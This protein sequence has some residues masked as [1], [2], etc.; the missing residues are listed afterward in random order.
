MAW[1]GCRKNGDPHKTDSSGQRGNV[2]GGGRWT[3]P[4]AALGTPGRDSRAALPPNLGKKSRD[5]SHHREGKEKSPSQ[6][7]ERLPKPSPR[8]GGRQ[9]PSLTLAHL[10]GSF[11]LQLIFALLSP[12]ADSPGEDIQNKSLFSHSVS[13]KED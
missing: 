9:T 13:F 1:G 10:W 7:L 8:P 2:E 11:Y 4:K 3:P 5:Q 12:G 6:K